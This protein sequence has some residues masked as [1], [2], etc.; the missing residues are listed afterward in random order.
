MEN[1]INEMKKEKVSLILDSI[2]CKMVPQNWIAKAV[3]AHS[4]RIDSIW[5]VEAVGDH[6]GVRENLFIF[7]W[8]KVGNLTFNNKVAQ[9]MS[10]NQEPCLSVNNWSPTLNSYFI[11]DNW[12]EK[13]K[14]K[15]RPLISATPLAWRK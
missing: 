15:F 14:T 6:Y 2:L 11:Q 3:T 8:T 9:V 7:I 10:K 5:Q 12:G 4:L 1:S 13:K